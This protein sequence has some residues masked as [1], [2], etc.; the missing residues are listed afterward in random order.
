M[1]K[2]KYKIG[3]RVKILTN[4]NGGQ[5]PINSIGTIT[6]TGHNPEYEVSINNEVWYYGEID[7]QWIYDVDKNKEEDWY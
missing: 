2:L 1:K 4:I 6:D 3:D 7:L 5:H